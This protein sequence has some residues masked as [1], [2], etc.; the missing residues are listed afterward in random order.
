MAHDIRKLPRKNDVNFTIAEFWQS[1]LVVQPTQVTN[2]QPGWMSTQLPLNVFV[3]AP[4]SQSGDF[5]ASDPT[6]SD[7]I[8]ISAPRRGGKVDVS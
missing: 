8:L 6:K 7:L 5:G 2:P 3:E 4:L 1:K